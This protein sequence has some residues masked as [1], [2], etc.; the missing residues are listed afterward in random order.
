[1]SNKADRLRHPVRIN[2]SKC[3]R[4]AGQLRSLWFFRSQFSSLAP[5]PFP[6]TIAGPSNSRYCVFVQ[7]FWEFKI[8]CWTKTQYRK[9]QGPAIAMGGNWVT[10]IAAKKIKP[11]LKKSKT[12]VQ[13]FRPQFSSLNLTSPH[14]H[15]RPNHNHHRTFKF[16]ILSLRQTFLR[17]YPSQLRDPRRRNIVNSSFLQLWRGEIGWRRSRMK[18]QN[19]QF[20]FFSCDFHYPTTPP[21][22]PIAI[23]AGPLNLWY[24]VFVKHFW[25]FTRHNCRTLENA[26]SRIRG[27]CDCDASGV[28]GGENHGWKNRKRQQGVEKMF[29]VGTIQV[30]WPSSRTLSCLAKLLH[31]SGQATCSVEAPLGNRNGEKSIFYR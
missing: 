3:Q 9:F 12:S 18:N 8:K 2:V 17:I 20:D 10:K 14:P 16:A 7:H 4:K 5:P 23:I 30:T 21:P 31:R 22:P 13:F 19:C 11:Q 26:I 15:P 1:M 27:S 25:E 28:G 29:K 24:W 6:I